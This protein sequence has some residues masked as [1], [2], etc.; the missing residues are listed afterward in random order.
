VL[1]SSRKV[2]E[3]KPLPHVALAVAHPG[4]AVGG[5]L[6]ESILGSGGNAGGFD[7]SGESGGCDVDVDGW[8]GGSIDDEVG[9][10]RH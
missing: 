5:G 3:C 10:G 8:S 7:G 2:N 9:S 6:L 4:P 1:T